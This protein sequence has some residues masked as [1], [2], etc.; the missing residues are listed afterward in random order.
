MRKARLEDMTRGWFI[1]NFEP[2]VLRTDAFEMG[3]KKYKAGEKEERHYHRV[4]SEVTLIVSGRV[5]MNG[6]TYVEGDIVALDPGEITDFEAV[7]DAVT[8]VAKLPS[9]MGDKYLTD[10]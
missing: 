8:A 7:T 5:K 1:G 6:V 3:V 2:V 10:D 9:L 4:A